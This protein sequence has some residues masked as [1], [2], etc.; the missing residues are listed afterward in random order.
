MTFGKKRRAKLE[1]LQKEEAF[2]DETQKKVRDQQ[3]RVNY[4][5]TWLETRKLV[6]GFGDDFEWTLAHPR[7]R[8]GS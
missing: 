3:P 8:G 2:L 6:N 7:A 4:L 5:V 1:Q